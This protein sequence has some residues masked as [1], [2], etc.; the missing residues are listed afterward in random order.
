[1]VGLDEEVEEIDHEM[2]SLARELFELLL[3]GLSQ[4]GVVHGNQAGV[5]EWTARISSARRG[6]TVLGLG[7]FRRDY[8]RFRLQK[9]GA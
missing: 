9:A 7:F 5:R 8:R 3:N 1:M 6:V 2:Q 4:L